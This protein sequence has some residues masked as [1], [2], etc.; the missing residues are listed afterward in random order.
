MARRCSALLGRLLYSTILVTW[1]VW[2]G[3]CASPTAPVEPLRP[4]F[5]DGQSEP[6]PDMC[7]D[8][9]CGDWADRGTPGSAVN[10]IRIGP[11]F[12]PAGC[13]TQPP[14]HR[15]SWKQSDGFVARCTGHS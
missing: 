13:S 15:V 12:A 4:L 2:L 9:D 11:C 1:G 10:P 8:V 6:P 3:S 14:K 5:E 7:S